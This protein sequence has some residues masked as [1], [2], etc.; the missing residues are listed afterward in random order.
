MAILCIGLKQLTT[1]SACYL[2]LG[3]NMK[4]VIIDLQI[5]PMWF[6]NSCLI[7]SH[8]VVNDSYFETSPLTSIATICSIFRI[9]NYICFIDMHC[10][11]CREPPIPNSKVGL[12]QLKKSIVFQNV[13]SWIFS[14]FKILGIRPVSLP[15]SG[16]DCCL[17]LSISCQSWAHI[18]D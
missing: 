5:R 15:N 9:G 1:L 8:Q 18:H 17:F 7:C 3:H 4:I 14:C 10:C 6:R 13:P 11:M 16:L 2:P 12:V